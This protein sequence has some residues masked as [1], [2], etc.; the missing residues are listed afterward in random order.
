[1]KPT[2]T[3]HDAGQSL[4]LD[5]ITRALLTSGELKRYI[6][7]LL[8]TGLTSNPTIFD[9]AIK[10]SHDYDAAIRAK[11][12]AGTTGE[13]LFFELA[14]EDLTRAA[15]L[16]R[17]IHT[18]T[19]GVDGWVSLEVSPKLAYDT[20]STVAAA[21]DLFARAGRP[22]LFIKIPGTPEGIP[23]IEEAIFA[24]VSVNVTLLFSREQYLAAAEAYIRGIERRVA[25]GLNP[26]VGSVASLFV[27]RWDGAVAGKVPAALE[28]QLGIAIAKRTYKAYRNLLASD[29]WLRLLNAGA[30]SQRLLW[31]S[32][33]TKD[34]KA[35]DILYIQ[36]LAAPHSVNTM[37]EKTL[38]AFADHGKTGAM[39]P[40][41]G[42]DAE[43]VLAKFTTA[44]I[45]LDALAATLQRDGAAAFVKSWD[46]LLAC[47]VDKSASLRKAG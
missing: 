3:L 45:D 30:R 6:D 41:D 31:A 35:S 33:G 2:Q 22:N 10:N 40:H 28:L 11:S 43:A 36:S 34:P 18:A 42:G 4:W 46:E 7:E 20:A 5:N 44:G 37:P 25:A 14:L 32:T 21:K 24:G 17:P 8:V 12:A 13:P 39:L 1:M 23:A 19:N 47:L 27:S 9:Q 15:D 16:F 26:H 38:L 29:R